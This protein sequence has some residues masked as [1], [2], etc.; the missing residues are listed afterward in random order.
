MRKF[1]YLLSFFFLIIIGSCS[2]DIEPIS[3]DDT[4]SEENQD[5]DDPQNDDTPE[6]SFDLGYDF[7]KVTHE[8]SSIEDGV[9]FVNSSALGNQFTNEDN[10]YIGQHWVFKSPSLNDKEI[11][12]QFIRPDFESDEEF[13]VVLFLHAT[14]GSES[15]GYSLFMESYLGTFNDKPRILIFANGIYAPTQPGNTSVWKKREINGLSFNHVEQ[16]M[17]LIGGLIENSDLF[18]NM[19]TSMENWTVTGFSAGS[20]I[21]MALFMDPL[22]LEN[23]QYRPKTNVPQG[24]WPSDLLYDYYDFDGGLELLNPCDDEVILHIANHVLDDVDCV[25]FKQYDRRD[26]LMSRFDEKEITYNYIGLRDDPG[27]ICGEGSDN[28]P[29]HSVKFY[30]RNLL[31]NSSIENGC[32]GGD[33]VQGA[34]LFGDLVFN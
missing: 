24:I 3:N 5:D 14:G 34:V 27:E 28:N 20:Q 26:W 32:L 2:S 17:E 9:Q 11:G 25:G 15:T 13:E 23:P 22:F 12:F 19:T 29:T 18:P 1:L 4:T 33:T 31:E 10:G 8:Y 21:S 7:R 6:S 16:L 30:Q